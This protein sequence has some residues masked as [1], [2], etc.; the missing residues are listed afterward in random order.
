MFARFAAGN[1]INIDD[2]EKELGK[3]FNYYLELY[4]YDCV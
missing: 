4:G 3:S 1:N 2:F